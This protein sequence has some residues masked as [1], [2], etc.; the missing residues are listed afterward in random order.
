M[1]LS[2]QVNERPSTTF[3]AKREGMLLTTMPDGPY[4][5][6]QPEFPLLSVWATTHVS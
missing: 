6:S 4:G 3:S 2:F 5:I 1:R